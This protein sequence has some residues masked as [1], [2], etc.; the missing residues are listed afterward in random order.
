MLVKK[1]IS[2]KKMLPGLIAVVLMLF[3]VIFF[4]VNIRKMD[5]QVYRSTAP[6]PSTN[7]IID[8]A[9][10]ANKPDKKT[11]ED[12]VIFNDKN[13]KNLQW[14]EV[15]TSFATGNPNIFK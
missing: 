14:I 6:V 8:S 2:L 12:D 10:S 11:K 13:F 1:K 4:V 7:V 15:D 3:G 9:P 5:K